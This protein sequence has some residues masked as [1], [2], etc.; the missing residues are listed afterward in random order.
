M[1]LTSRKLAALICGLTAT[2][3]IVAFATFGPIARF[4]LDKALLAVSTLTLA[5]IGAQAIIDS[6]TGGSGG[7]SGHTD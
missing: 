5:G 3:I 7:D 6:K 2:V 1:N 4:D